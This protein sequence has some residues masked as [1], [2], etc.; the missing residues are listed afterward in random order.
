MLRP[1]FFA[2][3]QCDKMKENWMSYHKTISSAKQKQTKFFL[4]CNYFHFFFPAA[5]NYKKKSK[6]FLK[7][8]EKS[9][10]KRLDKVKVNFLNFPFSRK[11]WQSF[12]KAKMF[13]FMTLSLFSKVTWEYL[14]SA[15]I[16]WPYEKANR[17]SQT[18]PIV[19]N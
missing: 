8:Q 10:G 19:Q 13:S 1:H 2:F 15:Q 12:P 4:W 14:E 17:R 6:L 7:W 5:S 16:L 18:M 3:F 9:S 11:F